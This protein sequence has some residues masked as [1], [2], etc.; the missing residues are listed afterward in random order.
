MTRRR[1]TPARRVKL[2]LPGLVYRVIR[3]TL[4]RWSPCWK[5]VKIREMSRLPSRLDEH[6]VCRRHTRQAHRALFISTIVITTSPPL[7]SPSPSITSMRLEELDICVLYNPDEGRWCFGHWHGSKDSSSP[8]QVEDV[9]VHHTTMPPPS[10]SV[11]T[12]SLRPLPRTSS[13]SHSETSVSL[14]LFFTVV[15]FYVF[16]YQYAAHPNICF[17]NK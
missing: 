17:P 11:P 1:T 7:L 3:R 12:P 10:S 16:I 2:R 8:H 14:S 13:P 9:G 6:P 5:L 4:D 15:V